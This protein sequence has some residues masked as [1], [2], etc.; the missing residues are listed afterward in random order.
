MNDRVYPYAPFICGE[1]KEF[2]ADLW[3]EFD[4]VSCEFVAEYPLFRL[5][6][7]RLRYWI[8]LANKVPSDANVELLASAMYTEWVFSRELK[9]RGETQEELPF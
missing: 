7:N 5:S 4:A 8:D 9:R 1:A 6:D 3:A 2:D